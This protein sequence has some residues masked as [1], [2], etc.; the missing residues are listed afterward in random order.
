MYGQILKKAITV[1]TGWLILVVAGLA[2][3]AEPSELELQRIYA[4]LP[5]VSEISAQ[6]GEFNVRTL[7]EA[8]ELLAMLSRV[9]M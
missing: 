3:A 1:L 9:T 2:T 4:V 7:R 8:D 6:E 5:Q